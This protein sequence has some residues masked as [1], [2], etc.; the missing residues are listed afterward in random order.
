MA[1]VVRHEKCPKYC[2]ICKHL[3]HDANE[4]R[5]KDVKESEKEGLLKELRI[6]NNH[7]KDKNMVDEQMGPTTSQDGA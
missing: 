6:L 1:H 5:G 3:A 2:M 7:T 4:C